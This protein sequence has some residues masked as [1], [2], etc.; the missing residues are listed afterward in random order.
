MRVPPLPGRARPRPRRPTRRHTRQ[1]REHQQPESATQSKVQTQSPDA[2]Y[3]PRSSG[4]SKVQRP[5]SVPTR[6]RPERP[7]SNVNETRTFVGFHAEQARSVGDNIHPGRDFRQA[8][9]RIVDVRGYKRYML[10]MYNMAGEQVP[11]KYRLRSP[12]NNQYQTHI[13]QIYILFHEEGEGQEDAFT[14]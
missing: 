2:E 5:I 11:G 4:G 9:D 14:T 7:E 8:V 12:V 1:R 10:R 6:Q 13:S 3:R